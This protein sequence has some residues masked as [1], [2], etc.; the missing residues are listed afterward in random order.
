[1]IIANAFNHQT[2]FGASAVMTA[3]AIAAIAKFMP[4]E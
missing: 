2:L 3:C 1:V 4:A